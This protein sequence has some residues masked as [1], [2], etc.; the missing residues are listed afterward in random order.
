MSQPTSLPPHLWDIKVE[1]EQYAR[2]YG[3]DF[4]ETS[5][6]VLDY[7]RMNEVAAY[8]G[9]PSRYPHWRFGMDYDRL[10]KG[11]TYGVQK[12]YEMVINNDPCYAY[13]L[14][15]N[16]TVDQKTVMAH[17]FA[18]CDFFKNNYWF[19]KTN[20][21]MM[22]EMA[23]HASRIRRYI[24]RYGLEQVEGFL[25][26]CLSVED[27]IDPHSP[28][29]A[30]KAKKVEDSGNRE[31]PSEIPRIR[32]KEYMD[33]FINPREFLDRQQRKI[34]KEKEKEL[35][36]PEEP[37]RDVLKFLLDHAPLEKWEREV[38]DMTREE[39]YNFA[40][41]G[42]G[43]LCAR[44]CGQRPRPHRPRAQGRLARAAAARVGSQPISSGASA[45]SSVVEPQA[46]HARPPGGSWRASLLVGGQGQST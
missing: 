32:A 19:G 21:K 45:P 44:V 2:D 3:L 14:E 29:I 46:R 11:H 6:E 22:D 7:D 4:F 8:G 42:R 33:E 13:L 20:R 10:S 37:E 9:F 27:L 15:G 23:N 38:L 16:S 28:F 26:T 18:H 35:R 40:P 25:D 34:E 39:A 36:F 43:T 5:F 17:V 24:E 31:E 30:R 1:V 12:I 41:R